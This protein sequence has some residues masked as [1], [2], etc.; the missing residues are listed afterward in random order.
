MHTIPRPITDVKP[1]MLD[2]QIYASALATYPATLTDAGGTVP[3]TARE[4]WAPGGGWLEW[5]ALCTY[6]RLLI[7]R[8]DARLTLAIRE[9]QQE[10]RHVVHD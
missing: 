1:R 8:D 7:R 10:E 6:E 3:G 4:M 2:V 9:H 5:R